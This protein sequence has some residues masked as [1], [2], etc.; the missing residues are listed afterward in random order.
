MYKSDL[1]CCKC[2]AQ[3][4]IEHPDS[5]HPDDSEWSL[6][7]CTTCHAYF[8]NNPGYGY[9]TSCPGEDYEERFSCCTGELLDDG[10]LP[11]TPEG[12]VRHSGS[13]EELV[14]CLERTQ[15]K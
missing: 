3:D 4:F 11:R 12:I 1:W 7:E 8:E 10:K 14:A 13:C 6:W 15:V 5:R 9:F 2:G